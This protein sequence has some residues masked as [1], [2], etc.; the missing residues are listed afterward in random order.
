MLIAER[1]NL[2]PVKILIDTPLVRLELFEDKTGNLF[3][4]SNTLTP[5]GTVYYATMPSTFFAFLDNIIT[6]QK[7]FSKSPSLFME[8]SQQGEET[9]YCCADTE[10]I[11][12][13]GDKTLSELRSL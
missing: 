11:L 2:V 9:L 12:V 7:L 4:G 8:I 3:L 5:G 13:L 10:I 6:L 1:K